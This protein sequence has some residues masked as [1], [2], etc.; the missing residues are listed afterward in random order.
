MVSERDAIAVI[1][2]DLLSERDPNADVNSEPECLPYRIDYANTEP[3]AVGHAFSESDLDWKLYTVSDD[4]A[5]VIAFADAIADA[6][7]DSLC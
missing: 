5:D 4:V 3:I 6:D 7:G 1:D 2:A